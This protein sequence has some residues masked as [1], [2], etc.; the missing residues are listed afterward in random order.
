MDRQIPKEGEKIAIL[1]DLTHFKVDAE[2]ADAYAERLNVGSQAIVKIG[3][4]KSNGRGLGL[5]FIRE[6]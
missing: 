6:I 4:T 2:I 5:L 1:S 3:T